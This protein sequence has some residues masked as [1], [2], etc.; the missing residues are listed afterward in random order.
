LLI[1]IIMF[2]LTAIISAV[3]QKNWLIFSTVVANSASFLLGLT[4]NST[5][6]TSAYGTPVL[7]V[8]NF[9]VNIGAPCSGIESGSLFI[10]FYI[11]IVIFDWKRINRKAAAFLWIPGLFGI[12]CVNILR[13]YALMLVGHLISPAL[14]TSIFHEN[15]GWMFFVAYIFLFWLVAYPKIIMKKQD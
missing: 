13:I 9:S 6:Y 3:L 4:Y 5:T 12:F 10:F 14:A 15:A 8:E 1:I 11:A 2:L 7:S